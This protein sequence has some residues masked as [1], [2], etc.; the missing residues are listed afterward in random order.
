MDQ[1]IKIQ[2]NLIEGVFTYKDE[3]DLLYAFS[4][5]VF[6]ATKNLLK[7]TINIPACVFILLK[8]EKSSTFKIA[9]MFLPF[10]TEEEKNMYIQ[11]GYLTIN[12]F[13]KQIEEQGILTHS[14]IFASE[15]S[16]LK[17]HI[18]ESLSKAERRKMIE[19]HLNSKPTMEIDIT[20][21]YLDGLFFDIQTET[22]KRSVIYELI[23][24]DD[25][26]SVVLSDKPE[27]DEDN[28]KKQVLVN[29][30]FDY[31]ENKHLFND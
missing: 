1:H 5:S 27:V 10:M 6:D 25:N 7:N 18:D 16:F 15:V 31:F 20:P 23:K 29:S 4:E 14:T 12:K 2:V 26:E 28:T 19:D 3:K 9:H 17:K 22:S 24:S 11:A 8:H 21:Q 13:S 30:L